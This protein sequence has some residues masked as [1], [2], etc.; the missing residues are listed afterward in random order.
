[1]AALTTW[2][3][4]EI[5]TALSAEELELRMERPLR[6]TNAKGKEW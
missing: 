3:F 5:F 1:M 2:T 6:A 4:K